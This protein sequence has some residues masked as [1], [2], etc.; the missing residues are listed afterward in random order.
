MPPPKKKRNK[1]KRKKKHF[2]DVGRG[3]LWIGL[4]KI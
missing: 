1:E 3:S 2:V 4:Y